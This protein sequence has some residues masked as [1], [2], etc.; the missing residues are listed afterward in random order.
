M[1]AQ[2]TLRHQVY[3][4]NANVEHRITFRDLRL[5]TSHN[6]WHLQPISAKLAPPKAAIFESN[7]LII[8]CKKKL[9]G[10]VAVLDRASNY[11]FNT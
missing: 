4:H 8:K 1:R 6:T 7:D 5:S 11:I 2:F 9:E 3:Y 10:F